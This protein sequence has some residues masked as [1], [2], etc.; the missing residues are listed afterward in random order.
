MN[1]FLC[2]SSLWVRGTVATDYRI[3]GSRLHSAIDEA[4]E[5]GGDDSVA[6]RSIAD[7][8]ECSGA[9]G[10]AMTYCRAMSAHDAPNASAWDDLADVLRNVERYGVES[11]LVNV[12]IAAS[13]RERYCGMVAVR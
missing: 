11:V 8:L 5:H 3:A 6:L 13:V 9:L 2:R 7:D 10:P 1:R 4:R 12:P